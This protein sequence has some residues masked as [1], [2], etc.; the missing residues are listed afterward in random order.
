MEGEKDEG[1]REE[2]GRE[3]GERRKNVGPPVLETCA[4]PC[5]MGVTRYKQSTDARINQTNLG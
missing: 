2:E 5:I 4:P 1:R 3:G